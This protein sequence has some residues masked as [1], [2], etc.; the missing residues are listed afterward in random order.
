MMPE[1]S[2]A[3][4]EWF[5][6]HRERSI[7]MRY[8]KVTTDLNFVER[9]KNVEKFWKDNQIFKKSMENRKEGETYTFYDGPPT[10]NGKP[11]IGHVETRVIKDMIP[12]FQ[13]MKGK[14]V[15]RK[16]GWDTHG[17]PVELEVEKM[18][19]LDGKEQIEEYGLEPFISHCKDSVWKY[20]G[21][22]EDFS[23]TV[24]FWAD[25]DDPYVTY[26]N[27]FIESEWWA[28][29]KIWEKGL[30]YKG[31]KIVPYCPRCGTPLSS[32]EVAQG[33]KD[34][35][36]RSAIARFKVKEEDAY[37]LAWTTTP[38][39][40]PSNVALCVNPEETYIKVKS[41]DGNTYYLA[42]ALADQVLGE[43]TY[44]VLETCQG[45]DLEYK[46]YE[47]LFHFK[48]LNK[49]AYY[50]VCDTYVTMSDGTG[51]V[52][53]APAF[54][55]DDSKVGRKYDLPFLQLV[56]GKGEMTEETPWAGTFCKNADN[57][58]LT[59]LENRG[60]L[61]AA[62]KFE[63]SYPH[64]WRCDT[65]LIYYARE[66]WFIKMTEVKDDLIRNN[67]TINWIPESIGK[68]RFGDWLENVQDWGISRNR[69][70]GTPLNIW[71]CECGHQHAVGSI[72]E[73]KSMSDNCPDDI[74]LHR[75]FIDAVTV[76]CPVCGKEMHRVPEVID[77]WFD[78]GAM[79]FAQHHYP[80]ENQDV[81]EKQFPARFIS[82]AVDQTRG[83]FY[84]LLAIST[85][86]FNKAP[87]ENVIVLG[88]VQDENGQKMSK[89]KGNAVD[90]FEALAT[91]GA[92]AIRWYFYTAGA[93]WIPKRFHGRA[94]Q[95]G[96][97]KFM[98]T[99]WNTY[100]FY[101]LYA[102]IDDFNP[103]DH[104]LDYEKLSVMDK[105]LLSKMNTMVQ[106]VDENLSSYKIPEAAR[107]LQDFVDDMSNWYVRRSRERFWAKGME[108]DKINAYMTLYT[109][110][111]TVSK[112]A[113]PM[114]PFMTEDIYQNLVRKVDK[115]APESIHLCDFPQVQ[116]SWIDKELEED[117]DEV[118]K[119]VV[120]G[121][122]CRNT[123]NI[124]N[125]QPIANMFVKAP[126]QLADYFQEIIR[127][128]L[129]TKAVTFTEDV[130][131]F[132]SYSFKPQL[133]TVGPKYG[134]LLGG[135]K[136]ALAEID[137]NAAMDELQAKGQIVLDI[138]GENVVLLTEDLLIET[139]QTEGYVSAQEGEI[140]VALDTKL[141]PELIEEGFVRE[142]I[143]K[144]Q[145][146]RKEAGFEVMDR[147]V[148]YAA[149]NHKILD[150]LR[151]HTEELKS[152]VL[153]DDIVLEKTD[154]YVKEWNIN[155][156]T[157]TMGV[158][159]QGM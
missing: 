124:K 159:K 122:A 111:V 131:A 145:T 121:R 80:F 123:A 150:I 113:A 57:L 125:R 59:D 1:K 44:T 47:P 17:L 81:F 64:C 41:E 139:A 10:A 54:G 158:K 51:V 153:A 110:L 56:D 30:L 129:N 151:S 71:E 97:R 5:C 73:L 91:Y 79:P 103:A 143:S 104:V 156:E 6:F 133:K 43:G 3:G 37:I 45:T 61:F 135:I 117:M 50:V 12:R 130:R 127:E 137:G 23:A 142:L 101:V 20:K 2:A 28:L 83:W 48:E 140:M 89:S 66:S 96:Q 90:P 33:Y 118:L 87:Y 126:V 112:A 24:G 69:Y 27:N 53:I 25:M 109:A 74:E 36:E 78:S 21:M 49:K 98:G 148:V 147:I 144:V 115:N 84:S 92:D 42:S 15:P 58:I 35:K 67:N 119:V 86:I 40:L 85:L 26:D 82:E 29:K 55:E 32:H 68:G 46:E 157:V 132:T 108:Q 39:T 154:G 76:K 99:L 34:V 134:K 102:N 141:T 149:G 14:M 16:A 105:W 107:V 4:G 13:T 65:P 8:E 93:P 106:G 136:K 120:M 9:E 62:P 31:Y 116:A 7:V 72:E 38:W 70:W 63:H 60:L 114:I 18:L 138:N 128:E 100:A 75:P 22:W 152:E 146:M 95:E 77:C 155:G 19:G 11:H 94:V 88:H 52:H